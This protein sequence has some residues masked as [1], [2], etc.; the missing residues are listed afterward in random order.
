MEQERERLEEEKRLS[1]E[2][3]GEEHR[4]L[5]A[6]IQAKAERER[7]K[8]EEEKQLSLIKTGE[9]HRK[10]EEELQLKAEEERQ[11]LEE[12][13][14]QILEKAGEEQ[15]K[16]EEE[17]QSKLDKERRKLEEEKQLS[18]IKAGEEHKKLVAEIQLKAEKERLKL[19]EEKQLFLEKAGGEQRK[20][21]EEWQTQ[22]EE[23]RRR[24]E[25]EK[26]L[27]LM[28]AGEE[29]RKL[30]EEWQVKMEEELQRFGEEKRLIAIEAE[31]ARCKTE[32]EKRRR[33]EA[34]KQLETMKA[35]RLAAEKQLGVMKA[36]EMEARRME[37]EELLKKERRKQEQ[38]L[39]CGPFLKFIISSTDVQI[40][41]H[42][43]ELTSRYGIRTH[44]M[45]RGKNLSSENA[46]QRK[47]KKISDRE[48]LCFLRWK[49]P[50]VLFQVWHFKSQDDGTV[51]FEITMRAP[52]TLLIENEVVEYCLQTPCLAL[53]EDRFRNKSTIFSCGQKGDFKIETLQTNQICG[54]AGEGKDYF[55]PY[56]LTVSEHSSPKKA[57][58]RRAYF[59]GR[60]FSG[61]KTALSKGPSL[62]SQKIGSGRAKAEFHDGSC[63][64]VWNQKRLTTGLGIYTSVYSNGFWY[65]STQAKWKIKESSEEQLTVEGFWPWIP[66]A[67]TWKMLLRDEKKL[68]LSVTMEVFQEAA[69]HMQ[70]TVMM[71]SAEYDKWS[72]DEKVQEFPKGFTSDDFFRF[73]LWANKADGVSSL[74]SHS[75]HLPTVLFKPAEMPGYRVIVENSQH[76]YS[77]QSRLFHCLRVNKKEESYFAPGEYEFFKGSIHIREEK[78]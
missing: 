63:Q 8:L 67:Q 48:V 55:R 9:H 24:L 1:L 2:K 52:E 43:Q 54:M 44:F 78:A 65:D 15:R 38:A 36:R 11:K 4:K 12:E 58:R 49:G 22:M 77:V 59:N 64:L 71:M 21:A 76:I 42:G 17:W 40:I 37:T 13:K 19:E 75:D 16:L 5:A 62:V 68:L 50:E 69:I 41:H 25:E 30:A 26:Q 35:F 6:E 53:D 70:E 45:I 61:T 46:A 56:F 28:K 32:E 34:E 3:A 39:F 57:R 23:E 10:L 73:C 29:H 27:N 60:F 7:L 18:L 72:A 47:V 51:D 31:E 20:L 66:M 14:Q 33:L 74:A